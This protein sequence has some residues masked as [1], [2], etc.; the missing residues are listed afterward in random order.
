M[1]ATLQVASSRTLIWN[2][3]AHLVK[4]PKPVSA[5]DLTAALFREILADDWSL[6]D[7]APAFSI[8]LNRLSSAVW[9]TGREHAAEDIWAHPSTEMPIKVKIF[10]PIILAAKDGKSGHLKDRVLR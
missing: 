9:R 7:G 8:V 2:G 4:F 1:A 10:E 6:T 5:I 3:F